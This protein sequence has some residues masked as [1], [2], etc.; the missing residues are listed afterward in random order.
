MFHLVTGQKLVL[1][2]SS[3][4]AGQEESE[5]LCQEN[6]H[7]SSWHS[8]VPESTVGDV[9]LLSMFLSDFLL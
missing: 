1:I 4:I 5:L 8:P 3:S 2:I 9:S 6:I 7:H